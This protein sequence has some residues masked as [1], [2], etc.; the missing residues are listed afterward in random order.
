MSAGHP[1]CPACQ[2]SGYTLGAGMTHECDCVRDRIYER[3]C[4]VCALR[5]AKKEDLVCASC[6]T[7]VPSADQAELIRLRS[8]ANGSDSH[9]IKCSAVVRDLDRRRTDLAATSKP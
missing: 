6:W 4:P 8:D 5:K 3:S 1:K 9:R 7:L 2:G